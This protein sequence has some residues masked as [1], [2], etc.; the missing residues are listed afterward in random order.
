LC[1]GRDNLGAK[2]R[3]DLGVWISAA[4]VWD[5]RMGPPLDGVQMEGEDPAVTRIAI[6]VLYEHAAA[7]G[8]FSSPFLNFS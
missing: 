2:L 4:R 3:S 7:V 1:F 8:V 6:R 5:D